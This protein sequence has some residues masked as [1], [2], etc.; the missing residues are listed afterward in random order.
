MPQN[1]SQCMLGYLK[2]CEGHS[3]YKRQFDASHTPQIDLNITVPYIFSA[4]LYPYGGARGDKL[5]SGNSQPLKL[6][7]SINFLGEKFDTI[8][9]Q[10][11]GAIVFS[12]KLQR[13]ARL[14]IAEPV[15]AVYWMSS[16]GGKVHFRETNEQSILNLAQNEVNIQYRYGSSFRPSSV[17]IVTWDNTRD[18]TDN[19]LDANA[20]QSHVGGIGSI[21]L[22]RL[23]PT[24]FFASD[25]S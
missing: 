23:N 3:R 15:I 22:L 24:Q 25:K 4:R 8:Y 1:S 5:L 2:T 21:I 18:L 9:V 16:Q 13:P 19:Y 10:R 20:P 14:P 11:D 6:I 17:V 12:N 7:S